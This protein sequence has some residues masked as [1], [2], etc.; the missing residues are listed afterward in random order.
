MGGILQWGVCVCVEGKTRR[1]KGGEITA[2]VL[3]LFSWKQAARIDPKTSVG[4][5]KSYKGKTKVQ[6][7]ELSLRSS[8]DG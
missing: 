5:K 8:V 2:E 1:G 6:E 4:S 3:L 7:E